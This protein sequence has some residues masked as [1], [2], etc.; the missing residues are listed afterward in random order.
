MEHIG[1]E[2]TQN[3]SDIGSL[4]FQNGYSHEPV[5][6][7]ADPLPGSITDPHQKLLMVLSNIGYCRD[8]LSL[9]LYGKYKNIWL[10]TRYIIQ[11]F[12]I[13]EKAVSLSAKWQRTLSYT[14]NIKFSLIFAW[15]DLLRSETIVLILLRFLLCF[16]QSFIYILR[17]FTC[18]SLFLSIQQ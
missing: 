8:E 3:R 10:P 12:G 1:S 11:L 4:N 15:K 9:E 2:L 14:I 13:Y 17:A 16:L 18:Y 7:S 6:T 5:E